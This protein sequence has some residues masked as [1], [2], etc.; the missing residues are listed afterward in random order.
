MTIKRT[1]LAS[2]I[3]LVLAGLC[4]PVGATTI[5]FDTE[6]GA[7]TTVST[8]G[9][10]T[11]GDKQGATLTFGGFTVTAGQS[12]ATTNLAGSSFS[13]ASTN[14]I[15][16]Y[17]DL[18]PSL[19]G[20]GAVGSTSSGSANPATDNLDPNLLTTA[21]GDEVLFFNFDSSTIL[22]RVNFNG[23]Q[24]GTHNQLV[25][26]SSANANGDS[27]T[28]TNLDTLFNIFFSTDGTHYT[29]AFGGQ[30]SPTGHEYLDTSL[31]SGYSYYAIAAS[32]WNT[33]PGGYVQSITY[34]VPEPGTLALFGLGLLGLV[35]AGR[36][37]FVR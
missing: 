11:N 25:S 22:N 7:T 32:G 36:K 19:G 8:T 35:V 33:A 16:A 3:S 34:S 24:N 12:N 15:Q 37:R 26:Y 6:S 4:L 9:T 20:L 30:K 1:L 29:S 23:G 21:N 10:S 14:A 31:T 27:G 17:Q 2:S 13:T 18:Q 28:Y 5:T